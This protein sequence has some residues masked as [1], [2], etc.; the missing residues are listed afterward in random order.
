MF[1]CVLDLPPKAPGCAEIHATPS[2]RRENKNRVIRELEEKQRNVKTREE[3]RKKTER[4][5]ERE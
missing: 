4:R 2:T 3:G 1:V 5:N